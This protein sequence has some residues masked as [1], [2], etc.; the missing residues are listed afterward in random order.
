[1]GFFSGLKNF[2]SRILSGIKKI[3][4]CVASTLHKVMGTLSGPVSMLHSGVR[5]MMGTIGNIADGRIVSIGGDSLQNSLCVGLR[6][7]QDI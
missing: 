5:Q 7:V 4:G 2:G 3:A 1:M 6:C